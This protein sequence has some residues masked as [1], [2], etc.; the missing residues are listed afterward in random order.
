MPH[1][2]RVAEAV[3]HPLFFRGAGSPDGL[4]L[5]TAAIEYLRAQQAVAV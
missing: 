3:N 2:E 4:Q 5:F 1:P